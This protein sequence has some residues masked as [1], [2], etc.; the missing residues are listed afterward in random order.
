MSKRPNDCGY[1]TCRTIPTTSIDR[2]GEN[3]ARNKR[4]R[5][6]LRRERRVRGPNHRRSTTLAS[7]TSSLWF[8]GKHFQVIS[9]FC[10]AIE[11]SAERRDATSI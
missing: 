11:V 6:R 9:R 5:P 1:S 10:E 3:R 8:F 7:G 4:Q 2:D